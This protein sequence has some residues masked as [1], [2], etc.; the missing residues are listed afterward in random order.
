MSLASYAGKLITS[1]FAIAID[2]MCCGPCQ[3]QPCV[4]S[5]E[6]N[7]KCQCIRGSCS[8][9]GCADDVD[10]PAGYICVNGICV[11][12]CSGERCLDDSDCSQGCVCV[13]YGC[14]PE[15]DVYYCVWDSVPVDGTGTPLTKDQIIQCETAAIPPGFC[16]G[17][18][19]KSC[20]RGR[21]A[22][23]LLIAGGPFLSYSECCGSRC[24][25]KYSCEPL[26]D[27][28]SPDYLY[29]T[30]Q[31]QDD[32]ELVCGDPGDIGRCCEV[33]LIRDANGNPI[34]ADK[35]GAEVCP[36]TRDQCQSEGD[37][38][39]FF[40]KTFDDCDLCPQTQIGAC[41]LPDGS[42]RV[43]ER[44]E[45]TEQL[46][47]DFKGAS[48]SD[49][50]TARDPDVGLAFDYACDGCNGQGDCA[51]GPDGRCFGQ[52]CDIC[53]DGVVIVDPGQTVD[54]GAPV[55]EGDVIHI[56]VRNC[57][58]GVKTDR[59]R[60]IEVWVNNV[61]QGIIVNEAELTSNSAGTLE[62]RDPAEQYSV[63]YTI[64]S[65]PPPSCDDCGFANDIAFFKEE[66][67]VGWAGYSWVKKDQLPPYARWKPDYPDLLEGTL[68]SIIQESKY[69]DNYAAA[70]QRESQCLAY[71]IYQCVDGKLKDISDEAVEWD[72]YVEDNPFAP[73]LPGVVQNAK[74]YRWAIDG[75]TQE[76]KRACPEDWVPDV[77]NAI[78]PGDIGPPDP[79]LVCVPNARRNPLQNPLP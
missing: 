63:C 12:A 9:G 41:C 25:C 51:C 6:C 53:G 32:C 16:A 38:T 5:D 75:A 30:F 47:G 74:D 39:R 62:F 52:R 4:G 58:N 37:V 78:I 57:V 56:Y 28:C 10:C 42:C 23:P 64:D 20:Q 29:G 22:D 33:R 67:G 70:G 60:A 26:V 8:P 48:W 50:D 31:T 46:G 40:N 19:D 73:D 44:L 3:Q 15:S 72:N 27:V 66:A 69:V 14:V 1:G 61:R 65:P 71:A 77:W 55:Q 36:T 11:P 43:A 68:W 24:D 45:C 7:P 76:F 79:I 59:A 34:Y 49:C 21:P 17:L 18:P 35:G 54:T 13:E 2:C